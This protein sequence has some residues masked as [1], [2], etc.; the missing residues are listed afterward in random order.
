MYNVLMLSARG[1]RI[2]RQGDKGSEKK[3]TEEYYLSGI[4]SG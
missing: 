4:S 2:G 1:Q 3:A